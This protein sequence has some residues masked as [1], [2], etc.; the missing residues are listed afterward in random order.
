[1]VLVAVVLASRSASPGQAPPP[2]L[3]SVVL[4]PGTSDTVPEHS[5]IPESKGNPEPLDSKAAIPF[6]SPKSIPVLCV[7]L[8]TS[9]QVPL[10]K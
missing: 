5:T 6:T 9:E 10:I 3:I 8:E 7:K 2:S 4:G 1:M